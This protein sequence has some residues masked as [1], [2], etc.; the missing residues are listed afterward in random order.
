[1]GTSPSKVK[2][3]LVRS[4]HLALVAALFFGT[5]FGFLDVAGAE[6]DEPC[7]DEKANIVNPKC[8]PSDLA[9]AYIAYGVKASA[10][11]DYDQAIKAFTMAI[12]Y[13]GDNATIYYNRANAYTSIHGYSDAINDYSKATELDP[14]FAEAFNNRC[15]VYNVLGDYSAA[16]ADCSQ[17]I[18]I[19]SKQP[20]FFVGRAT[21]YFKRGDY[22]QALSDYTKS[23]ELSQ[24]NAFL[25]NAF[26][27]RARI[28]VNEFGLWA[29]F[30]R[31]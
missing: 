27:G 13:S 2:L 14:T 11:Q 29:C 22:K 15:Y 7:L 25:G 20:N 18:R 26:L 9:D 16:I 28:Y 3:T 23:I 4:R 21:A 8:T 6:I 24:D 19:N 1:M 5:I 31:S 17:A 10:Q 12:Q 30:R